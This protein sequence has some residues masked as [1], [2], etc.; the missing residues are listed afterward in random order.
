MKKK[1]TTI[2]NIFNKNIQFKNLTNNFKT[3]TL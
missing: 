1:I 2:K 3:K